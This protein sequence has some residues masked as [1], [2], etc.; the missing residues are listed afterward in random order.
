MCRLK[1]QNDTSGRLKIQNDTYIPWA[2][3]VFH[4]T[5]AC[6]R[7]FKHVFG[8]QHI[9]AGVFHSL[10]SPPTK[11]DFERC[12]ELRQWYKNHSGEC[13]RRKSDANTETTLAQ[14]LDK[15]RA[16][17]AR[18]HNNCIRNGASQQHH[19]HPTTEDVTQRPFRALQ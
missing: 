6:V 19:C 3:M 12:S 2:H 9:S 14:W 4:Y 11:G 18:A 13:P 10:M 15:A 16:R 17:R 7:V 8:Q 5:R 1:I